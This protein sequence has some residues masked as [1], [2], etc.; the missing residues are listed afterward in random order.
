MTATAVV[1]LML[2]AEPLTLE[3]TV[4]LALERNADVV[5]AGYEA[6]AARWS[7]AS[8]LGSV[9]PRLRVEGSVQVW[10]KPLDASF[11]IPG[12]P[13]GPSLR[14]RD[15]VTSS[16]Q[17]VVIQ[18]LLSLWS[19]LEGVK[20][21]ELG[22]DLA[23]IK[24]LQ[25][26]RDVTYQATE[27][28]YRLLQAKSLVDV[29]EKSVAQVAAQVAKALAFERQGMMGRNDVLRAEIALASARQRVLQAK[30]GVEISLARLRALLR[31]PPD[32]PLDAHRPAAAPAS[33]QPVFELGRAR[34]SALQQRSEVAE[35][36]A[37]LQQARCGQRIAWSRMLPQINALGSYQYT[38]GQAL[39]L[40]DQF[41]A[42]VNAQWDVFE[43]GAT[44][45]GTRE[46][47][48]RVQQAELGLE[49]IKDLIALDIQTTFVTWDTAR[50]ALDVAEQTVVQAEENYRIVSKKYENASSTTFDVI[51]AETLLTQAR[52]QREN[53]WFDLQVA[54]AGMRRAMGETDLAQKEHVQ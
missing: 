34:D 46:A 1:A 18:P 41:F 51:D 22:I 9:G 19:I 4:A 13:V 6:E 24:Q 7:R 50:E 5:N 15:Q 11:M 16:A 26:R 42:G 39:A 37:R 2:S 12:A 21:K 36:E 3:Q 23:S 27:A 17:V 54:Q 20:I 28:W 48:V 52:A 38:Q 45:F 47:S 30:G 53:A 44:Y 43:W 8:S 40:R 29:N 35:I 25:A 14:V 32:A 10:D 49:R 33:E 31:Q